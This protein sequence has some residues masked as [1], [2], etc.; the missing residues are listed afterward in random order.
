MDAGY[1][2]V[3]IYQRVHRTGQ[4]SII[5]YNRRNEPIGFDKHFA[6]TCFRE[7][8][9]RYDS[10][11]SKYETL[12]YIHPKE[13]SDCPLAQEGI[14]QKVFKMKI[15]KDLRK[16]TAPAR[17]SKVWK[18]LFKRRTA[19]ER[20]N[21]YLKEYCQLN[22]VRYRSGKCA[23]IHSILYLFNFPIEV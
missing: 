11:D 16:Y 10:Y 12:K 22:N 15:M 17:G 8:S 23:K 5:A 19:V 3:P 21:G 4:Q 13:C 9:Y 20:V 2:Y 14:C 6:P 7:Y 1:D 18:S